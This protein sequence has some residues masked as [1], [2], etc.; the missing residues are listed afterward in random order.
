MLFRSHK[1]GNKEEIRGEKRANERERE[2]PLQGA[3]YSLTHSL[4]PANVWLFFL[5]WVLSLYE[6][7]AAAALKL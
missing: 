6:T 5:P 1:R 7:A 4:S 3:E 2:N